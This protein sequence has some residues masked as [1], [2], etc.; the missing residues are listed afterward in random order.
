[1]KVKV[2]LDQPRVSS[3][4]GSICNPMPMVLPRPDQDLSV[5]L[6]ET[7]SMGQLAIARRRCLV[8]LTIRREANNWTIVDAKQS[9]ISKRRRYL[10]LLR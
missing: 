5:G 7:A 10:L 9:P 4:G 2:D 8:A 1:M 6:H 3:G